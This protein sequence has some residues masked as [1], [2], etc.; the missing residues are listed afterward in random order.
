MT[1]IMEP[2]STKTI[3]RGSP[4]CVLI[5]QIIKPKAKIRPIIVVSAILVFLPGW[6]MDSLFILNYKRYDLV[7]RFFNDDFLSRGQGDN[8]VGLRFYKLD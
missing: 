1:R 4:P 2:G 7:R 8:G 5:D 3:T 6:L